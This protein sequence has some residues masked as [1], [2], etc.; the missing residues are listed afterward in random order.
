MWD[1]TNSATEAFLQNAGITNWG[2]YIFAAVFYVVM[3]LLITFPEELERVVLAAVLGDVEVARLGMVTRVRL[4]RNRDRARTRHHCRDS[5]SRIRGH[6]RRS[7]SRRGRCLRPSVRTRRG[8]S[9]RPC[10]FLRPRRARRTAGVRPLSGACWKPRMI[11]VHRLELP[12]VTV[13][14]HRH[15]AGARHDRRADLIAEGDR[16]GGDDAGELVERVYE[17][18]GG[19]RADVR[20]RR[21][22]NVVA[23]AAAEDLR[24]RVTSTSHEKPRRGAYRLSDLLKLTPVPFLLSKL[25]NARRDTPGSGR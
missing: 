24:A 11:L 21:D 23:A 15:D 9:S 10:R 14:R 1:T 22:R 17:Q 3:A 12:A 16:R 2:P 19:R 25:S 20:V 8:S 6:G 7:R 18:F 4:P 5:R 13:S